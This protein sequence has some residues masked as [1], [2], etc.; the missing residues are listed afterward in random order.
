MEHVWEEEGAAIGFFT[1]SFFYYCYYSQGCCDDSPFLNQYVLLLF[2][3]QAVCAG[4]A[5]TGMAK[6]RKPPPHPHLHP[7]PLTNF[8]FVCPTGS[9]TFTFV[10]S[11]CGGKHISVCELTHTMLHIEYFFIWCISSALWSFCAEGRVLIRSEEKKNISRKPLIS[12]L[13][14]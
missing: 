6:N 13:L 10:K 11:L 5:K 12:Q 9:L 7:P 2:L 4:P 1:F 14:L 3:E 8:V